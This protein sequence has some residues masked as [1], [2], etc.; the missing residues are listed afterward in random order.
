ML[1]TRAKKWSWYAGTDRPGVFEI[2]WQDQEGVNRIAIALECRQVAVI[3]VKKI[4]ALR[5]E[6]LPIPA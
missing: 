2:D 1:Q 5:D 6:S 3:D 4:A